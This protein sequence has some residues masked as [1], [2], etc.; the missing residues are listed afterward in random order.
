MRSIAWAFFPRMNISDNISLPRETDLH[1]YF[2]I[3]TGTLI[4]TVSGRGSAD[5]L[6]LSSPGEEE[7]MFEA[8]RS[9]KT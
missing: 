7:S 5:F 6:A 8:T 1:F 2:V 4:S 9:P 3:E